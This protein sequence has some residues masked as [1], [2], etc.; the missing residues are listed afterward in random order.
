MSE[1]TVTS[2]V[3][4]LV[5]TYDPGAGNSP[6]MAPEG[7]LTFND[8]RL[9]DTAHMGA[10]S[11][12][13]AYVKFL[14]GSGAS[15]QTIPLV[16]YPD[17][18]KYGADGPWE[19]IPD[20]TA[21]T[22]AYDNSSL[23]ALLQTLTV[24]A[25]AYTSQVVAPGTTDGLD[26]AKLRVYAAYID[27]TFDDDSTA[28]YW[29]SGTTELPGG[30]WGG[31][32]GKAPGSP[33]GVVN[34]KYAIDEDESTYA[35]I[36]ETSKVVT[37][38]SAY[39]A[40]WNPAKLVLDWRLHVDCNNPPEGHVGT[41][42]S[43]AFKVRGGT[44]PYTWGIT[45]GQ[46][47][48]GLLLGPSTGI[49]SGVP[50]KNGTYSFEL[51]A[52]EAGTTA[53][54]VTIAQ[55]GQQ[56]MSM[57]TITTGSSVVAAASSAAYMGVNTLNEPYF[58][59]AVTVAPP[60]PAVEGVESYVVTVQQAGGAE[61]DFLSIMLPTSVGIV[62]QTLLGSYG[63]DSVQ[64]RLY[65]FADGRRTLETTAWSGSSSQTVTI[66]AAPTSAHPMAP[67]PDGPGGLPLRCEASDATYMGKNP[68][69]A[70]FWSIACAARPGTPAPNNGYVIT[71]NNT[72]ASGTPG[73]E[74]SGERDFL[75]IDPDA[76]TRQGQLAENLTGTYQS[77]PASTFNAV[78][79]KAYR[80]TFANVR[81]LLT[82]AW[83]GADHHTVVYGTV[84]APGSVVVPVVIPDP[85]VA[86]AICSITIGEGVL[87]LGCGTPGTVTLGQPFSFRPPVSFGGVTLDSSFD[88]DGTLTWGVSGLPP[89]LI[90]DTTVGS[91]TYGSIAG[92]ATQPGSYAYTYTITT[93]EGQNLSLGCTLTVQGA[94]FSEA[95]GTPPVAPQ[96][97]P[98]SFAPPFALDT[99]YTAWTFTGLPPG[100][101][102]D[103]VNGKIT[104]TPSELGAFVY[105]ATLGET[106]FTCS[107]TVVAQ[108][109]SGAANCGT[110]APLTVGLPFSFIPPFTTQAPVE[111]WSFVGLPPG[112]GWDIDPLSPTYGHIAGIP[113]AQGGYAYHATY[114]GTTLGG[115]HFTCSLIVKLPG[116]PGDGANDE[117]GKG[118]CWW[119]DLWVWQPVFSFQVLNA[120]YQMPP[121]YQKALRYTLARELAAAFGRD[122]SIVAA[123]AAEAVAEVDALNISDAAG[124]ED[125]PPP[126]PPAQG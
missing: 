126:A 51:T 53:A 73:G 47:P 93:H 37:G 39:S 120:E 5:T 14:V 31:S 86:H 88:L 82:D 27:V 41:P 55:A 38:I 48:P 13:A 35:E 30:T 6:R 74:G 3:L 117:G 105:T 59:I 70:D 92:I 95:C 18:A 52:T 49:A 65:S 100:L 46:L 45:G 63:A 40:L 99:D 69:N 116:D 34:A 15:T 8:L 54:I 10:L 78:T 50:T 91:G 122:P 44:P 43:H 113:S 32:L 112:L 114:T 66:G 28:R 61:E 75:F 94:G 106:S 110:P 109:D 80:I 98:Y 115:M 101:A 123:L 1:R 42:Y 77:N 87:T 90:W 81:E 104:G 36:R 121:A 60:S 64:F 89:G 11:L 29:A 7:V 76:A 2:A 21:T 83:G 68:L 56:G 24:S 12:L 19:Y 124:T 33:T 96:W 102:W 107:I 16:P 118:F 62:Q 111:E 72:D 71:V 97:L 108:G 119:L 103:S 4:T 9:Y 22:Y 67:I 79:F 57:P 20:S 84:P 23:E 85:M 125:P 25:F 17:A 58:A 26:T